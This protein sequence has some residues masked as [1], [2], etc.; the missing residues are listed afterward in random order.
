MRC[1]VMCILVAVSGSSCSVGNDAYTEHFPKADGDKPVEFE[2]GYTN[3][4]A[5]AGVEDMEAYL[6]SVE[7]FALSR[8]ML[9][10]SPT[11]KNPEVLASYARGAPMR[12]HLL[13]KRSDQGRTVMGIS[14]L[15]G[16]GCEDC[17]VARKTR[18]PCPS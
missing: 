1:V 6:S 14:T 18:F 16:I 13:V 5:A 8:H 9:R 10:I 11:K 17:A 2:F 15:R 12:V 4:C 7:A 3:A